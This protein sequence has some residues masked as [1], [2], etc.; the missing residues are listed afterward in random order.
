[1]GKGW[2]VGL[3]HFQSPGSAQGVTVPCCPTSQR[4]ELSFGRLDKA[5]F[6]FRGWVTTRPYL[7]EPWLFELK[8]QALQP[9]PPDGPLPCCRPGTQEES[10]LLL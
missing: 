9:H 2:G 1:M 3:S 8:S 4:E 7:G 5:W 10:G 6:P